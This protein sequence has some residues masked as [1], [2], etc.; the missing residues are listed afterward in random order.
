M[1]GFFNAFD[2]CLLA[3]AQGACWVE[4]LFLISTCTPF[5]APLFIRC[6]CCTLACD[7]I[8]DNFTVDSIADYDQR[9]GTWTVTGGQITTASSP[10]MIIHNTTLRDDIG[11]VG[12]NIFNMANGEIAGVVGAY[13]D[14]DNYLLA[15]LECV[16]SVASTWTVRLI[17]VVATV[18]TTIQENDVSLNSLTSHGIQL[19]WNGHHASVFLDAAASLHIFAECTLVGNKAGLAVTSSGGTLEFDPFFTQD[20]RDNV[21]TCARCD[22][23]C[24]AC[25]VDTS[26]LQVQ[27][28]ILD[29]GA[30]TCGDCSTING[31]HICDLEVEGGGT[32]PCRYRASSSTTVGGCTPIT[33][34]YSW[35]TTGNRVD[36]SGVS[37]AFT[38]TGGTNQDCAASPA[39]IDTELGSCTP[40]DISV[41]TATVTPL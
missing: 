36:L 37:C 30:G 35:L 6:F 22:R 12:T 15:E 17:E 4:A 38:G 7:I 29:I 5:V 25:A 1:D 41:A 40:C 11:Q 33:I 8:R 31:T 24:T 19:C 14:D 23:H 21:T 16:D 10:A 28:D 13:V 39:I 9:V 18:P 27:V 2:A 32:V 3:L 26:G 34:T 20:S